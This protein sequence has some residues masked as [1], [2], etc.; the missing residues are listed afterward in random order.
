MESDNEKKR[1]LTPTGIYAHPDT[2]VE[3]HAQEPII[4]AALKDE[5]FTFIESFEDRAQAERLEAIP[6]AEV[7]QAEPEKAKTAKK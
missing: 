7:V 4:A 6:E 1:N 2:G 3:V 5:G